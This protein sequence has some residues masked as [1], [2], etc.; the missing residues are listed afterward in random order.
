MMHPPSIPAARRATLADQ[1]RRALQA[2]ASGIAE[3]QQ[4]DGMIPWWPG[5]HADPWNHVEA[6]MALGVAGFHSEAE[7]A[8]DWLVA[9]QRSDGAWHQYYRGGQIEQD[10]L[11]ANCCA[12]VATG[13]WH[14]YVLSGDRGFLETM[15]PTVERA[16]EFVL[17]LQTRR[18]EVIWARHGDGTPW[19]FALLTGS[20]SIYHSIGC[21]LRC[22]STLG[23][24]R[25][26]W[27]RA[28]R[29]LGRVVA[30]RPEAFAP[31]DRWAMDW[32]YP[33]LTG[34]IGG[35]AAV[36]RLRAGWDRFVI[37]G[38]GVR[39]VSDKNWVTAA[40]TAECAMAHAITG[41][42]DRA[43]ALL[44]WTAAHRHDDGTYLTGLVLPDRV[45]FPASERTTYS[46]AAVVLATDL[47]DT[48][49]PTRVVFQPH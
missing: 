47:L 19:S 37:I 4:D 10:K 28:R 20:S 43:R 13:V 17:A 11:D 6:T 34:V 48:T 15:W 16:I 36:A 25:P 32:Y 22:A 40:E 30:T 12:Y 1:T 14:R 26:A 44:S 9:T 18:G 8:F 21:A 42:V 39:C 45:V 49:S 24:E 33:V 46:A 5:G 3:W 38:E 27:R 31:K 23:I 41:E 2:T 7:R 29:R 35:T